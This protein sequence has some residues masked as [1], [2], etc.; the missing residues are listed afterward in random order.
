[1]PRSYLGW[2]IAAAVLCFLPTGVVAIWFGFQ[3]NTSVQ[4]GEDERA[5]RASVLAR[6]WLIVTVVLGILAWLVIAV[7]LGLLGATV[8]GAGN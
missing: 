4:T 7:V 2:S 1:M 3:V 8:P 6:R 5:A